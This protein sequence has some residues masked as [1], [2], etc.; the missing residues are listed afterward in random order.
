MIVYNNLSL[1]ELLR[2][3]SQGREEIS[4]EKQEGQPLETFFVSEDGSK[5]G[6]CE[7]V[8]VFSEKSPKELF[9]YLFDPDYKYSDN[10]QKKW[11]ALKHFEKAFEP[12]PER[13]GWAHVHPHVQGKP[14]DN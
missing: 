7:N 6:P 3:Y 14:N 11:I 12:E 10:G 13:S 9:P 1:K 4:L 8:T 2:K 5:Q